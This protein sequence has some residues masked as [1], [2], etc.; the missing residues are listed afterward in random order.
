MKNKDT[1][2]NWKDTDRQ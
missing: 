2:R 1:D